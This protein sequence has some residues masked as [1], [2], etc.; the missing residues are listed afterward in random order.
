ML[1]RREAG[2]RKEGRRSKYEAREPHG[3]KEKGRETHIEIVCNS[4]STSGMASLNTPDVPANKYS[5]CGKE[6]AS[7]S[8]W[9]SEH[10]LKVL[11]DVYQRV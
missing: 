8:N 4:S 3:K 1:D 6:W 10:S 7:I 5:R 11:V 9:E 2:R